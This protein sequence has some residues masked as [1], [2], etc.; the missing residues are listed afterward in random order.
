MNQWR[1]EGCNEVI[2]SKEIWIDYSDSEDNFPR[3][4][5]ELLEIWSNL[6]GVLLHSC[7]ILVLLEVDI[8]IFSQKKVNFFMEKK[9]IFFNKKY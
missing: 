5:W 2:F 3:K 9:I 4:V 8:Q 6:P 7:K 1:N